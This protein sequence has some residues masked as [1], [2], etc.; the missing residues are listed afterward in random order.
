MSSPGPKRGPKQAIYENLAEV[1]Q[2][3]GHAH[4]LELLEHLAQ[5]VRSV[6]QL[7]ARAHLTFAN[8]S[9]HLQILRRSRLVE[10]ERR[11]KN[12][13]YRLAGDAEVVAMIKA[14]GRIGERNVAEI[15]RVVTD[16]FQARDALEP[17]SRDDLVAKLRDDLVTLLDVRPEDEFTLGH[18]PGAL[19]IPLA[20]LERRLGEL[21]KSR[22]V[23]AYCRGPYCVLSFE[24]VSALRARGY[25][26][27]RLEDGYPEWKAAGLPVESVA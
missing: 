24:A 5:G 9:R 16:Y 27:R 25:R 1:A 22:E 23:I 2:A 14:L 15:G 11:G 19:N 18:L 3:L 26:V 13:L 6:E 8:T 17:V 7:S 10:T 4:R 12:V 21:S 20:E